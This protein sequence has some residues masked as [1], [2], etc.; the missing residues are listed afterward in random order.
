MSR[1]Y[2][3]SKMTPFEMQLEFQQVMEHGWKH[4]PGLPGTLYRLGGMALAAGIHASF[5]QWEDGML[6]NLDDDDKQTRTRMLRIRLL[7]EEV[8]EYLKAEQ[9]NDIVE[10]ADALGDIG[11][12]CDGTA[13]EYGIPLDEV[14]QEIHQSNMA[15]APGG[16]VRKRADNKVLKPEGWKP[17]NIRAVLEGHIKRRRST[18]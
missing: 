15:K 11:V 18:R 5:K 17:P 13:W 2:E 10:I 8:C 9:H 1:N 4:T 12:I 16:V 14:R 7:I 6:A 3:W